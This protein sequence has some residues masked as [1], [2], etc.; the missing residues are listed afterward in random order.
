MPGR[1]HLRERTH[2]DDA[3]RIHVQ[4]FR[5]RLALVA[6]GAV[7]IV[8]DQ[9]QV[10]AGAG[11]DQF[12]AA[13]DRQAAAGRVL[14]V[15]QRVQHARA[16]DDR[17]DRARHQAMLVGGDR[18]EFRAIHRK[19][20]QRAEVARGLDQHAAAFVDQHLAEQVER[21]LRAGRHQHLFRGDLAALG[22]QRI[23]DPFAQRRETVGRAV[24]QGHVATVG[25][26]LVERRLHF[27]DR[28]GVCRWQAAGERDDLGTLGDFQDFADERALHCAARSEKCQVIG[29][30]FSIFMLVS[31]REGAALVLGHYKARRV[32]RFAKDGAG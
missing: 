26:H 5:E 18:G 15:R 32:G 9:R 23:G 3:I 22:G 21:L 8:L 7:R 19:R 28:E 16:L 11:F 17:L 13:L 10:V 6:Q 29:F 4:H 30:G 2:V 24:L 12:E 25:Q 20:L 1:E 14:E 31:Q 27:L